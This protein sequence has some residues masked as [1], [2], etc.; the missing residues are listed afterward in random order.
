MAQEITLPVKLQLD[1]LQ[2]I[3]KD[4]RSQLGNLK[5]NSTG[6]NKLEKVIDNI[7][8]RIQEIQVIASRPMMDEKQF[9]AIEKN[10]SNIYDDFTKLGM[11][12]RNIKF[13]DLKLD[14]AQKQR[15]DEFDNQLKTI[16][17]ALK[18][19]KENAKTMF[20]DSDIGKLW[21]SKHPEAMTQS[22][23]Q[24]TAAIRKEVQE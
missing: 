1:N 17:D 15:L 19:V 9:T 24:I 12:A 23:S 7:E 10:I 4:M 2:S 20:L 21:E 3:A 5:V 6:Y 14:G 13:S 18:T 16:N 11:E 22:F 8:K